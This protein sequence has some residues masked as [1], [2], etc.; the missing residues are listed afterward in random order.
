MWRTNEANALYIHSKGMLYKYVN[1]HLKLLL[2]NFIACIYLI[3]GINEIDLRDV[4]GLTKEDKERALVEMKAC[5]GCV[6]FDVN[7]A[8]HNNV[9]KKRTS[10][11]DIVIPQSNSQI[12]SRFCGVCGKLVQYVVEMVL[13]NALV[14]LVL[15]L[16][17]LVIIQARYIKKIIPQSWI[18]DVHLCVLNVV[19]LY[20]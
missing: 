11:N 8:G 17:L 6:S 9:K 20:C 15:N 3:Q 14:I 2:I 13:T 12:I 7:N 16:K 18:E 19:T 1:F 10:V 4:R 5:S